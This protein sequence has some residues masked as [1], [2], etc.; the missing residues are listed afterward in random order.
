MQKK[1]TKLPREN[2][3]LHVLC[4]PTLGTRDIRQYF[5]SFMDTY[6]C[7]RLSGNELENIP[8]FK[9]TAI[10]GTWESWTRRWEENRS[11]GGFNFISRL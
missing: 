1:L 8:K 2:R 11:E 7:Q 10:Q 6:L 3:K 9:R 5:V 4:G